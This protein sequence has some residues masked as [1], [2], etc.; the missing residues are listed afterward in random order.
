MMGRATATIPL[1]SE[2]LTGM[3]SGKGE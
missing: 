1:A 3:V 2:E